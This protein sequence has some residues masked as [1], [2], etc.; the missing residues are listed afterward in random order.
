MTAPERTPGRARSTGDSLATTLLSIVTV[1]AGCGSL[2]LSL[3]FAMAADACTSI[4]CGGDGVIG[5]AYLVTWGGA[6]VAMWLTFGGI[7]KASRRQQPTWPWP[8]AGLALIVGTFVA[9]L[10]LANSLFQH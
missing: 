9:G 8:V 6:A 5:L 2:Q 10:L 1:L 4:P 7:T 3:F